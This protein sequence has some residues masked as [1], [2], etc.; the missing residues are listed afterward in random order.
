MLWC[1]HGRQHHIL[2]L[3]R[4][5]PALRGVLGRA[6]RRGMSRERA[7]FIAKLLRGGLVAGPWGRLGDLWCRRRI[8]PPA[9]AAGWGRV[10]PRG[11]IDATR[12]AAAVGT[13]PDYT[14]GRPDR[15]DGADRS[16]LDAGD[17]PGRG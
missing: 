15:A 8:S 4:W 11:G 1:G 5:S 16:T 12:A 14:A 13:Y 7:R 6:S 10:W 2:C 17:S 9:P 3:R